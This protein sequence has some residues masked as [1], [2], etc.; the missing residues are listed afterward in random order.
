MGFTICMTNN[1]ED[2]YR[3]PMSLYIVYKGESI[4]DQTE[5]GEINI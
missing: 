5:G 1:V 2:T 3:C 4:S